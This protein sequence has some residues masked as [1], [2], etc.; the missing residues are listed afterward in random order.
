MSIRIAV[1]TS[2][3]KNVDLH[4]GKADKFQIYELQ[5]GKF[6]FLEERKAEKSE[7]EIRG[8]SSAQ[9]CGGDGNGCYSGGENCGQGGNCGGSGIESPN[10]VLL[11]DC[12]G[13][14]AAKFGQQIIRQFER[15][16]VSIFDIECP[17]D[18]ALEKLAA[19]YGKNLAI[20]S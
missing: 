12:A 15:K 5:N 20:F 14:V 19:Y 9:N 4:F 17:V 11:S 3:G 16:A 2:D 7:Y 13:I 10:V 1:A 18:F 6:V 8:K